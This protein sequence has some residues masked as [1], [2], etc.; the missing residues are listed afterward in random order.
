M[1]FNDH[2][3]NERMNRSVKSSCHP[4]W[5]LPTKQLSLSFLFSYA[6]FFA[7]E[8][9]NYMFA[10]SYS[11]TTGKSQLPPPMHTPTHCPLPLSLQ[12]FP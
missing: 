6:F 11:S 2:W 8:A 12:S 4:V 7:Q 1:L 5:L 9:H 10:V 3:L